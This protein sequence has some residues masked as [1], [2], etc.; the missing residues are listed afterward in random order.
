MKAKFY[1]LLLCL[2]TFFF[3]L[4]TVAQD[5]YNIIIQMGDGTT[6]MLGSNE[7]DNITFSEGKIT[8]SGSRI[9]D[10]IRQINENTSKIKEVK[11]SSNT[12]S[13]D[14]LKL[15]DITKTNGIT[16]NS[17]VDSLAM[18]LE[19]SYSKLCQ[20]NSLIRESLALDK[21]ITDS[22][23]ATLDKQIKNMLS[24]YA[25]L[26]LED[27]TN[28]NRIDSIAIVSQKSLSEIYQENIIIRDSIA[29][30]KEITDSLQTK[31]E[32]QKK[33]ALSEFAVLH[34]ED[35]ANSN[36]IDSIGTISQKCFS[37]IF[38]ENNII[39]DSLEKIKE[40]AD[41]I[42]LEFDKFKNDITLNIETLKERVSTL[43]TSQNGTTTDP[44]NDPDPNEKGLWYVGQITKTRT[45]FAG[46]TAEELIA[47]STAY[48]ITT[49]TADITINKSCWFAM[50][51][52]N[53]DIASAQYIA[54]GITSTF[55]EE[56]IKNGFASGV[57]HDDVVIKGVTYHVYVNRNT[58]LIDYNA[59]GRFTLK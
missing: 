34:L 29:Q 50:V 41:S 36:R 2:A 57:V 17:R 23:R 18:E 51:P 10:L 13:N 49:K 30:I 24:E 55:T 44:G 48:P 47:V 12:L 42:Q 28:R 37:E 7:V 52:K 58:A 46:L 8:I 53:A 27:S 54:G 3:C 16:F 5:D 26:R 9:D 20:E 39:R 21:D 6:F 14:I 22:L 56:E 33:N 45:Q 19:N 25:L 1:S 15:F 35:S 40:I 43:E 4:S 11:E 38:Q 32:N 59:A 31:L